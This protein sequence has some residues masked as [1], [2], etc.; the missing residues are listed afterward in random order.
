MARPGVVVDLS[1]SRINKTEKKL[2]SFGLKFST[3]LND[4]TPLHVARAVNSFRH[5][6]ANNLNVPNIS[7][8]RAMLVSYLTWIPPGIP[9]YQN[10]M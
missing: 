3:G 8:I 5:R 9:P 1:G 7:F 10:D 4:A 6:H 2:L